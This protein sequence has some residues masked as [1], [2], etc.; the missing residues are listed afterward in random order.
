MV[1]VFEVEEDEAADE[2]VTD[3][4]ADYQPIHR[5]GFSVLSTELKNWEDCCGSIG[6]LVVTLLVV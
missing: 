6:C 4:E 3:Q 2:G 1:A 5:Q